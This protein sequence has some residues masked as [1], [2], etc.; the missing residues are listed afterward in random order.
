MTDLL[1][2]NNAVC[3]V[4][5]ETNGVNETIETAHVILA[6]GHS[7]RDTFKMLF[8][9][10]CVPMEPKPFSMGVRIEHPQRQ[11]NE[12]Q[13]GPFADAPGLGAADY[14]PSNIFSEVCRMQFR[15]NF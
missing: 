15:K 7:A 14:I 10:S 13:Y 11:I 8:E 2:K 9:K 5:A 4:V 3:G 12:N 6:I 1:V